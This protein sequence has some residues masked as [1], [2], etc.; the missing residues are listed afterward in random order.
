M[1]QTWLASLGIIKLLFK[2]RTLYM[3]MPRRRQVTESTLLYVEQS[4]CTL[5]Y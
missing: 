3:H 4:E 5:L 2:G 1:Y